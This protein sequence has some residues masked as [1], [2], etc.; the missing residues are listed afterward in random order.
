MKGQELLGYAG[1]LA[2]RVRR[3]DERGVKDDAPVEVL[4]QLLRGVLREIV[5]GDVF[6]TEG[7]LGEKPGSER[8]GALS[9]TD[10]ANKNAGPYSI[11][12]TRWAGLSK[13]VEEMGELG[14]VIGK[15]VGTGGEAHH[16][17][18][19]DLRERLHEE[20]GDVMAAIRFFAEVNRLDS[21]RILAR[22]ESKFARFVQWQ[23]APEQQPAAEFEAY[24][25]AFCKRGERSVKRLYREGAACCCNECAE[26]MHVLNVEDGIVVEDDRV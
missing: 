4:A 18:G 7:Y 20:I 17:D 26:R 21:A 12:S 6:S 15:L 3:L 2:T 9:V 8:R 16:W 11:G 13:L 24:R 23:G 1:V 22:A 10:T 14:Q 25:C 5:D 19:S